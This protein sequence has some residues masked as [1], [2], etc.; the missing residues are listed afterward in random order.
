MAKSVYEKYGGFSQIGRI[1]VDFYDR[2]LDD[3][4]GPYFEDVD[5]PRVVDHQ[6]KFLAMLLGGP[7]S[8]TD[9]QIR[10]LHRHLTIE[11]AHFDTLKPILGETLSDHGVAGDDVARVVGEFESRRGLVVP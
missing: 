6:T 3:D 7:A 9:E 2:L 4:L 10:A 1:V 5:M 11:P 8:Y